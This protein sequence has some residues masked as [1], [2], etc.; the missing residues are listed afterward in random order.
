MVWKTN[1]IE[2]RKM[3]V[4]AQL[5]LALFGILFFML[6]YWLD[7]AA[8]ILPANYLFNPMFI[9]LEP[10]PVSQQEPLWRIAS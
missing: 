8:K 7:S 9:Q 10:L 2:R 5:T 4:A 6:S 3:K 1:R